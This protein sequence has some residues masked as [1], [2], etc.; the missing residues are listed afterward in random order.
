MEGLTEPD[1]RSIF[2]DWAL[3]LPDG[4]PAGPAAQRLLAHHNP[5]EDHPI[6]GLLR[7]ATAEASG[8]PRRR[9]GRKSRT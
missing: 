1:A 9:G 6:A 5:A 4:E 2:F 7:A 8:G 3:G